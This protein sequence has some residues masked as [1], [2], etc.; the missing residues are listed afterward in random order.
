MNIPGKDVE[1]R[2][3]VAAS[4]AIPGRCAGVAALPV[5]RAECLPP[6]PPDLP[7]GA[8]PAPTGP[9]AAG[10]PGDRWPGAQAVR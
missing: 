5:A 2:A 9:A 7:R 3:A 4:G 8:R 1:A 6:L 10:E